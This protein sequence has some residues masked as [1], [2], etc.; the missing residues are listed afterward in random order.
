MKTKRQREKSERRRASA[1]KRA[2]KQAS[3]G[4]HPYLKTPE[5]VEFYSFDKDGPRRLDIIEYVVGKGNPNA[6]EGDLFYERT[7][8]VHRGIGPD[9]ESHLCLFKTFKKPCPVCE[10]KAHLTKDPDHDEDEVKALKPSERQLFN[11]IDPKKKKKGIQI[12]DVSNF[13]F[14][15]LLDSKINNAESEKE[16]KKLE[17]FAS[18]DEGMQ[19]KVEVEEGSFNG[20][21][22]Y[23]ANAIEFKER[24][25]PL[26]PDLVD[27]AYCLDDLLNPTPYKE[28]KE[29]FHQET[30]DDEDDEDTDDEED[31]EEDE[32]EDEKPKRK[33]KSKSKS[34]DDEDDDSESDDDNADEDE[35]DDSD[36]DDEDEEDSDDEEESDVSVGD[37]VSFSYKGK[38]L[39]GK[40]KRIK[41]GLA[42]VKSKDRSDA[43]IVDPDDLKILSSK[44]DNDEDEESDEEEDE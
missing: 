23:K 33:K 22:H 20:R 21:T 35:D 16:K 34:K 15:K 1:S 19:L 44:D 24:E 9:N 38:K 37:L 30:D 42:H 6:E 31:A 18:P 7:F 12:F 43:Y 3:G 40:V 32:D 39:K 17:M 13:F 27:E 25:E 4:G 2:E 41:R 11:V 14:G 8:F 29:L 10:H 26:D 5:G 36:S 28:L